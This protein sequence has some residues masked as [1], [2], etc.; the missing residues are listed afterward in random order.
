MITKL[1][2]IAPDNHVNIYIYSIYICNVHLIVLLDLSTFNI[3]YSFTQ[4]LV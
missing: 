4:V 1:Q 3:G 2:N